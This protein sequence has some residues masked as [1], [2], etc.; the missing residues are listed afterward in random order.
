MLGETF[1]GNSADRWNISAH[2]DGGPSG[3]SSIR[4]PGSEDTHRP[5]QQNFLFLFFWCMEPILKDSFA[6]VKEWVRNFQ[7]G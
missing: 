1:E 6:F 5:E 2:V 3:G 7:T 4:G